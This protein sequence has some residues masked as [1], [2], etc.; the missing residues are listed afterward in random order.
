MAY[1]LIT[2]L[3][4][5]RFFEGAMR[6]LC[7]FAEI[8]GVILLVLF[9]VFY[10]GQLKGWDWIGGLNIYFTGPFALLGFALNL[11]IDSAPAQEEKKI[12]VV[13][14]AYPEVHRNLLV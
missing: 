10:L 5:L 3:T 2:L 12:M 14:Q 6:L 7:Y 8:V 9:V 13:Y 1:S 11:Y 4:S